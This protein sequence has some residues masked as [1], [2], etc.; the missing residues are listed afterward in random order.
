L[1]FAEKFLSKHICISVKSS[2][3][4]GSPTSKNEK[5]KTA[6]KYIFKEHFAN[7]P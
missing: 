5:K 3:Q 7:V 2:F 1:K 4:V 6:N